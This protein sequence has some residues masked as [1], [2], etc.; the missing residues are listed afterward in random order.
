MN[1]LDHVNS[2]SLEEWKIPGGVAQPGDRQE[3][4]GKVSIPFVA[5][6]SLYSPIAWNTPSPT[7]GELASLQHF[8]NGVSCHLRSLATNQP[9][10]TINTGPSMGYRRERRVSR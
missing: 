5:L 3:I 8:S 4:L 9:L 2:A 10:D 1:S 7:L 6:L